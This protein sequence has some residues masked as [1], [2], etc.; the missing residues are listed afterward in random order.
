MKKKI[1]AVIIC[2]TTCALCACGSEDKESEKKTTI[3]NNGQENESNDPQG[4]TEDG[5]QGD[6]ESGTSDLENL[7]EMETYLDIDT[8]PLEMSVEIEGDAV[9]MTSPIHGW[10]YQTTEF[11]YSGEVLQS[12]QITAYSF[13]AITDEDFDIMKQSYEAMGYENVQ[14]D[15]VYMMKGTCTDISKSDY[16]NYANYSKENLKKDLLGE[17]IDEEIPT[18]AHSVEWSDITFIPEGMPQLADSVS[19]DLSD[20]VANGFSVVWN[21][22]P[23]ADMEVMKEKLEQWSGQTF[24]SPANDDMIAYLSESDKYY[25]SIFYYETIQEKEPQCSITVSVYK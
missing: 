16:W 24:T 22:L 10:G 11:L 5:T 1:L 20:P 17:E 8:I 14:K 25:M 13:L 9:V 23:K 6:E 2:M 7:P 21:E 18:V 3:S 12:V 15:D 4:E 19:D